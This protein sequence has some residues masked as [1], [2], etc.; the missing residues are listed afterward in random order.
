MISDV[1]GGIVSLSTNPIAIAIA[2]IVLWQLVFPVISGLISN[3]LYDLL[4][5]PEE[6]QLAKRVEHIEEILTVPEKRGEIYEKIGISAL[7][8][9]QLV[10]KMREYGLRVD[11]VVFE[12]GVMKD[13]IAKKAFKSRIKQLGF[14]GIGAQLNRGV[15]FLP[16]NRMPIIP[17]DFDLDKWFKEN[18]VGDGRY[19]RLNIPFLFLMDLAYMKTIKSSPKELDFYGQ[20]EKHEILSIQNMIELAEKRRIP[21]DEL[22]KENS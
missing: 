3:V 20:L 19:D 6:E 2:A 18:A 10:A 1:F 5:K 7:S 21:L 22:L 13:D 11:T 9:E 14:R 12:I 17:R 4:K 16:P 15:Y 8:K